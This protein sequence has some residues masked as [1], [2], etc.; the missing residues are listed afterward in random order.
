[1]RRWLLSFGCF[2][3]LLFF[4]SPSF[5][6]YSV[7]SRAPELTGMLEVR[8]GASVLWQIDHLGE[9]IPDPLH[10]AIQ[11][12]LLF[13]L[14]GHILGLPA[15]VFFALAPLGV[16]AVLGFAVGVLRRGGAGWADTALAAVVLGAGGWLFASVGWLG[17]FDSWVVLALLLVAFGRSRWT[18]WSACLWAPW[19]DERFV[20]GLP[21]ALLCR[22]LRPSAADSADEAPAFDWRQDLGV[23]AALAAAFVAVR[24]GLLSGATGGNAIPSTYLASLHLSDTPP[25]RL[26]LGLW[27]GLRAGWGFVAL[28]VVFC[29]TQRRR[30]LL[31]AAAT[32][33]VALV[34][35]ATAQDF[36]R[37][38]MFL[39]P[40]ALL[41][42]TL[43]FRRRASWLAPA[44]RFA[45]GATLLLPAHHVMN[46]R[47]TPLFY[48]HHEL[49]VLRSPP[50]IAMPELYELRAIHAMEAG[51]F[52]RA[53][54]D[55]A[56]AIKL[57]AHPAGPLK[58]RGVL[59]AS[60]GRW[61]EAHRDFA[62]MVECD[63][64]NPESW[65]FRAQANLA[66]GDAAAARRDLDQAL[67]QA[68]DGWAQRADVQRFAARLGSNR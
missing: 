6:A 58:Q 49:A 12:R 60:A 44:L 22:H 41:G 56:L 28:A 43:A 3:L 65:F 46:D 31:L 32:A 47:V 16:L 36:G 35:L 2:A 42:A 1:M 67:T 48:L 52:P 40:V 21:L 29:W 27:E 50:A 25:A 54:A 37:A 30:A 17:Y 9:A 5:G 26:A 13:P 20:I 38:L 34:S 64:A 19:I 23:P 51:D 57:S 39:T 4:F 14:L 62:A 45:A 66:L 11:W 10:G 15:P 55:L 59:Y 68:P 7:W 8:R 53:E 33:G 18:V 63:P 24:L 61:A